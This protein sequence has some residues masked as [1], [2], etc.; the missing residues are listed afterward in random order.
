MG[1]K[2]SFVNLGEGGL[3]SYPGLTIFERSFEVFEGDE[4]CGPV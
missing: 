4:A 2:E 1:L 3:K